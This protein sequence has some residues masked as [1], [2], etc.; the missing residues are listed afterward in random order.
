MDRDNTNQGLDTQEVYARVRGQ[1]KRLLDR[2]VLP[3]QVSFAFAYVATELGLVV[4]NDPAR[5]FSVVLD[6]LGQAASNYAEARPAVPGG[7]E[8]VERAPTGVEIH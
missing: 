5:V 6:A 1:V 3:A 4:S 8:Q 2:G 7:E